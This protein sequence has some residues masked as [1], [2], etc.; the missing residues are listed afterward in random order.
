MYRNDPKFSDGQAWANSVDPDQTAPRGD[1]DQTA[2][3]GAVW[4]GSTLLPFC[5]HLLEALFNV[6]AHFCLDF[7]VIT[8]M[9]SGV[10]FFRDFTVQQL[11]NFF[12][13]HDVQNSI[14]SS[15]DSP[16]FYPPPPPIMR[17]PVLALC[18]HQRCRSAC[19]SAQ[20]DQHHCFSLLRYM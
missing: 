3:L 5:L 9:Y 20:S 16:M 14:T 17:K 1:P 2:P 19:A 6:T 12:S 4:S 18:K 13:Q 15:T 8:A 11:D 10:R 7:R